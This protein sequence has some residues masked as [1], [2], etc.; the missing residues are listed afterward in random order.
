[1]YS[2]KN[3]Q[4]NSVDEAN[5]LLSTGFQ[6]FRESAFNKILCNPPYHVDF[7]VPK[8]F[9]EKGFNRLVLGGS[10]WM[11]TKRNAW[12]RKKLTSIFGGVRVFE[13]DSYYV[14]EAIKRSHT[15][16]TRPRR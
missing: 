8:L 5:V 4:L 12:Y 16:A 9:I 1:M 7:S 6:D 10:M 11:V 14:F 13:S 15:Y 3:I 2:K